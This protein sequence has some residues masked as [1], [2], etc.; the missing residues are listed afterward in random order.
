MAGQSIQTG[1]KAAKLVIIALFVLLQIYLIFVIRHETMD[2]DSFP[3]T[4][5]SPNLQGGVRVGQTFKAPADGLARIDVLLG[6]HGRINDKNI[7][8]HLWEM[9]SP[10]KPSA[11]IVFNASA[12]GNNLYRTFRFTPQPHSKSCNYLFE[13][14]SPASTVDNS[15]AVWM[16]TNDIYNAGEF[17]FN[18]RAVGGDLTFRAYSRRPVWTELPRLMRPDSGILGSVFVLATTILLLE[19]VL[20]IFLKK[21][22]D[23]LWK[24]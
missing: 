19:A 4:I 9:T 22:L 8:F 24:G 11:E 6:T 12:V 1:V 13:F 7:R 17:L 16:S 20:V 18:D 2:I 14:E 21:L 5:P 23:H 15:I 3:N 10:R